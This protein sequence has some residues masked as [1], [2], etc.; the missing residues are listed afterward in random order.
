MKNP[1]STHKRFFSVKE[2]A[3]YTGLSV[4]GIYRKLNN[5]NLRHYQVDGKKILDIR[6]L[7]AFVLANEVINSDELREN[8]EKK[9]IGKNKMAERN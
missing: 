2:A 1:K 9:L 3:V 8:L 5:R 7:D 4:T 6:D